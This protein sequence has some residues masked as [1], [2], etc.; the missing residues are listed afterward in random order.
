MASFCSTPHPFFLA[1]IIS[2]FYL[3]VNKLF[4]I[5]YPLVLRVTFHLDPIAVV[6]PL[7]NL[8]GSLTPSSTT[9]P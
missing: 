6:T 3:I 9:S 8:A 7:Q 4:Q 5:F 1:L 2:Y